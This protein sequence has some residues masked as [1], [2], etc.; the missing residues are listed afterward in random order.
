MRQF[1]AS[2]ALAVGAAALPSAAFAATLWESLGNLGSGLSD[3]LGRLGTGLAEGFGRGLSETALRLSHR[4]LF[5]TEGT[6]SFEEAVEHQGIG[7]MVRYIRPAADSDTPAPLIVLLHYHGGTPT[8][9]ANMT[10]VAEL[11]RDVGAWIVLPAGQNRQWNDDP[12]GSE[13]TD[14]VGFIAKVIQTAAARYPVDPK[15]VYVAGMSGGGFMATRFAC[16]RPELVAAIASVAAT[17]KQ[18]QHKACNPARAV[19]VTLIHGTRDLTVFYNHSSQYGTLS[20]PDTFA[21]WSGI[22]CCNAAGYSS[23]AL[24]N[25]DPGDGTTSTLQ[26]NGQC[27]SGGAVQ[28]YTVDGGG[29]TWPQGRVTPTLLGRTGQDFSATWAMWD[30]F[31]DYALP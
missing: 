3:G 29:H 23:I 25:L 18:N 8:D 5:P 11:A 27:T 22:H 10:Y 26:R 15:R 31:S 20:A 28:L 9:I 21:R 4:Y 30:F 2:A 7:R 13:R 24:P 17:M 12:G 14:D 1:I 6:V 19:P 16:E